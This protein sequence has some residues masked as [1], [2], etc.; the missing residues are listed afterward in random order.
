MQD[1]TIAYQP[2]VSLRLQ[3]TVQVKQYEPMQFEISVSSDGEGGKY[4]TKE[5]LDGMINDLSDY[6]MVKF[7]E[8]FDRHLA[9]MKEELTQRLLREADHAYT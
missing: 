8:E 9:R 7:E 2:T 4:Y 5:G 6:L 1:N 3:R